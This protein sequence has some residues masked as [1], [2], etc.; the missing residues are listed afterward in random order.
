MIAFHKLLPE[1]DFDPD[2]DIS[3]YQYELDSK[4]IVLKYGHPVPN[5]SFAWAGLS[6]AMESNGLWNEVMKT[7]GHQRIVLGVSFHD[8]GSL[9]HI[10]GMP[11]AMYFFAGTNRL[12]KKTE[13]RPVPPTYQ[14]LMSKIS[15]T[16]RFTLFL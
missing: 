12:L 2:A 14:V 1:E 16:Q 7:N 11:K 15:V 13:R 10:D 5:G 8:M 6:A 9:A 4:D 3:R